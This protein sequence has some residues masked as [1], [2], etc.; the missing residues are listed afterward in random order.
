MSDMGILLF[1]TDTTFLLLTIIIITIISLHQ[2][3]FSW[4][5]VKGLYSLVN[6]HVGRGS[7]HLPLISTHHTAH[8]LTLVLLE[9]Q[10]GARSSLEAVWPCFLG[11]Y[12]GGIWSCFHHA[13]KGAHFLKK[14]KWIKTN[15]FP[16]SSMSQYYVYIHYTQSLLFIYVF[17][18]LR[19]KLCLTTT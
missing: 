4:W 12:R 8:P 3:N 6:T 14:K 15:Y 13:G 1:K 5:T 9:V 10:T 19:G 2:V 18:L 7:I 16:L 11:K 17:L